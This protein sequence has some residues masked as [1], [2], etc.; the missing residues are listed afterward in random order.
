ME[1]SKKPFAV[2]ETKED[3]DK[4]FNE[5]F[6]EGKKQGYEA[7][8]INA[9]SYIVGPIFDEFEGEESFIGPGKRDEITPALSQYQRRKR[10][11]EKEN[12]ELIKSRVE[13]ELKKS[14]ESPKT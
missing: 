1:K 2:L 4:W 7:G 10:I 5:I 9:L 6:E 3:F 8:R 13:Y 11:K 12:E 14:S